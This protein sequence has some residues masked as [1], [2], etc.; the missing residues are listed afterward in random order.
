MVLGSNSFTSGHFIDYVI[1]NYNC[2]IIGISRSPEYHSIFLPFLYK[3]KRPA[4]YSFYQFDLNEDMEKILSEFNRVLKKVGNL[5]LVNMTEGV[6]LGS[7]I[8]DII[9]KRFN[10]KCSFKQFI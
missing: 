8:C 4:N 6:R 5:L 10:C 1:N 3:K 2:E 7:K 9:Y